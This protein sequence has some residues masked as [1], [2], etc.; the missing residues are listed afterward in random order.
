[1]TV[2]LRRRY[3]VAGD[4]AYDYWRR[5]VPSCAGAVRAVSRKTAR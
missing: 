2:H 5:H 3:F 1:M 4:V